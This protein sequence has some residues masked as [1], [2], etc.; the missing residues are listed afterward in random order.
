[1]GYTPGQ[2]DAVSRYLGLPG[3]Y[4]PAGIPPA[5]PAVVMPTQQITGGV[6][7]VP[8][9]SPDS[10]AMARQLGLAP[11]VSMPVVSPPVVAPASVGLQLPAGIAPPGTQPVAMAPLPPAPAPVAA[12]APV[13]PPPGPKPVAGPQG[14]GAAAA[15]P[16]AFDALKAARAEAVD[17]VRTPEPL[18]VARGELAQA[19]GTAL[20]A[21]VPA[22]EKARRAVAG[23]YSQAAGAVGRLPSVTWEEKRKRDE[24]GYLATFDDEREAAGRLSEAQ[25]VRL[26]EQAQ[27][28]AREARLMEEQAA[29][30]AAFQ[31]DEAD[32]RAAYRAQTQRQVDEVRE[33]KVDPGRYYRDANSWTGV[34]TA[35]GG[36]L[37]GALSGFQGRS[38]NAFVDIINKNID[39]DINAQVQAIGQKNASIADRNSLYAQLVASH[40][41][42][43]LARAQTRMAMLESARTHAESEAMRLGT[44]E[45]KARADALDAQLARQQEQAK[46]AVDG[47]EEQ[48]AIRKAQALAAARGAAAAAA[49]RRADKAREFGLKLEE[50]RLKEKQIDLEHGDGSSK[51]TGKNATFV[52]TGKDDKGNA[53]GFHARDVETAKKRTEDLKNGRALLKMYDQI[54]NNREQEGKLGRVTSRGEG[55]FLG[56]PKW[57]TDNAVVAKKILLTEKNIDQLGAL[58][59]SDMELESLG[60]V[61]AND[62]LG[63][64][65]TD[66]LRMRRKL[67]EDNLKLAEQGEAGTRSRKTVGADGRPMFEPLEG[68][69]NAPNNPKTVQRNPLK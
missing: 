45:A 17:V 66:R 67:V 12:P 52:A 38:D 7:P 23:A 4:A 57:K 60:D 63:D 42:E 54:I 34:L 33:M 47:A 2:L 41:D 48:A 68:P 35:V 13:G 32:A 30:E 51:P 16:E 15:Y 64:T 27:A 44:P 22:E 58:S 8:M 26:D 65:T 10:A 25:Q 59:G 62:A 1:M 28:K 20:D 31:R 9:P 29:N 36:A 55:S 39:R 3:G 18:R 19:Y 24:Q 6:P 50:Q 43:T 5:V 49:E 69:A 11:P 56:T 14:L 37:A 61:N 21:V 46:A 53:I 40:K